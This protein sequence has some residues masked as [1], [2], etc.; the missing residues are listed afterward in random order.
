MKRILKYSDIV[1]PKIML[2]F[3]IVIV[4]AA[5]YHGFF[6]KW[7]F[8]DN[9]QRASIEQMYDGD[10]HKPFVYRQLLPIV[11]K[12]IVAVLPDKARSNLEKSKSIEEEYAV[13]HISD[14]YHAEYVILYTLCYLA[15]LISILM[16]SNILSETIGSKLAGISA[17]MIFAILFPLFETRG[18]YFYDFF[19][20]MFFTFTVHFALRG[21][22]LILLLTIP[23]ATLNKESFLFFV[24]LL[25]PFLKNNISQ[26]NSSFIIAL[27]I[28]LSSSVY[29]WIRSQYT[30]NMGGTVEFHLMEHLRD[31]FDWHSYFKTEVNYG[32]KTGARMWFL[33][34]IMVAYIIRK[35]WRKLPI[36]WLKHAKMAL[37]V[38][39]PLYCLFCMPG[40]LRNLSML[41]MTFCV[42]LAIYIKELLVANMEIIKLSK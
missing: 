24:P 30:G 41:Y 35:T 19:E 17:A 16:M 34:V 27:G 28:I 40:E 31:L 13:A 36:E 2:I 15:F 8:L 42:M 10:A 18:G 6:A 26:K 20:L 3:F 7:G 33:Y 1:I 25:Y 22:W 14:K 4:T 9:S 11:T 5:G 39:L 23:I 21:K 32:F 37:V 38:Q 29:L 12:H